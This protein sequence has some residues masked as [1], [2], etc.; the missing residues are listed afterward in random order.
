MT[1]GKERAMRE[2]VKEHVH[3]YKVQEWQMDTS[4]DFHARVKVG[5][6]AMSE[7]YG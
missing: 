3:K 5:V 1:A 4:L 2:A 7:I 6:R